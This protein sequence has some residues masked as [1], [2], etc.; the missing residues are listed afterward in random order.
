MRSHSGPFAEAVAA[1]PLIL[2]E[3]EQRDIS[4]AVAEA[5]RDVSSGGEAFSDFAEDMRALLEARLQ[6]MVRNGRRTQAVELLRKVFG[7]ERA[8]VIA[9][10][11][12]PASVAPPEKPGRQA[13]P[14]P[15]ERTRRKGTPQ[16]D[17]FPD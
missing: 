1:R 12:I 10:A 7:E 5:A 4:D 6:A 8:A 3:K 17:L 9:A 14:D 16:Q 2:D 11:L 15:G 13:S